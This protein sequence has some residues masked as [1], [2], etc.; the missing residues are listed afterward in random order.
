MYPTHLLSSHSLHHASHHFHGSVRC[1][2][3][4]DR[5]VLWT[6]DR[7]SYMHMEISHPSLCL[8]VQHALLKSLSISSTSALH[9]LHPSAAY[10]IMF[11]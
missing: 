1:V 11:E 8:L 3:L 7:D 2:S 4:T 10:S 5:C 6:L 9:A